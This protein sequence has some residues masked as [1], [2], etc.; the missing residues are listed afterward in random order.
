[1]RFR[2]LLLLHD[3]L[4]AYRAPL[5]TGQRFV[6]TT[7]GGSAR[8]LPPFSVR[9]RDEMAPEQ[10]SPT[11]E[12]GG[13]ASEW[14]KR[15]RGCDGL[16][17]PSVALLSLRLVKVKDQGDASGFRSAVSFHNLVSP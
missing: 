15:T 5:F 16:R 8:G 1:M 2:W 3:P 17:A 10:I 13:V 4:R 7:G 14:G 12:K 9:A 6:T 11:R